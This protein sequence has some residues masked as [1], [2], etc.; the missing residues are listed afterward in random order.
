MMKII[1][2]SHREASRSLYNTRSLFSRIVVQ[3]PG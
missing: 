3:Q 1:D 2:A